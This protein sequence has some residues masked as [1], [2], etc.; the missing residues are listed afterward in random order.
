[1]V[2]TVEELA[3]TDVQRTAHTFVDAEGVVIHY[4]VWAAPNPR[5]VVQLEHGVGEHALR[6]EY[7]AQKLVA[8][9]YTV[10]AD[11]HRGH[12]ATGM[13][14]HGGDTAKLGTLGIG[15]HAATVAAVQKFT[16]IIRKAEPN[17]PLTLLGHSW[18]SLI[19]QIIANTASADYDALVLTGTA[20]R[21]FRDMNGGDLNKKHKHLGTTGYEW[22]SRD[23]ETVSR[24]VADPLTF[25]AEIPKLFGIR[26][27]LSLLGKPAK[28]LENAEL[29]LLIMVG[30]DDSLGGGTSA[31]K[32]AEAYIT[33]SGLTDVELVIYPGARHE[34]FNETNRDEV[35]ADLVGWLDG[36]F[37]DRG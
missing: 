20:F 3:V 10:Y 2:A 29:P 22:L 5:A 30:S 4:Y 6:Y 33:R 13:Q 14:Q 11:D 15:G 16:T 9:G 37:P 27:A 24:F 25:A 8:A 32:L 17:L 36:H 7:L 19:A 12:G 1:M 34:I 21:T 23:P 18:G 35:I 31:K 26:D 28:N